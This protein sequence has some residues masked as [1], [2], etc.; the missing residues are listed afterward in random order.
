MFNLFIAAFPL[1]VIY[2]TIELKKK[3]SYSSLSPHMKHN[4]EE[5]EEG[6]AS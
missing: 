2:V 6:G 3:N 1:A 5:K 4:K